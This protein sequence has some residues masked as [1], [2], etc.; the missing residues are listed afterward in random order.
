MALESSR[1]IGFGTSLIRVSNSGSHYFTLIVKP[2][3]MYHTSD[4]LRCISV[5]LDIEQL[6]TGLDTLISPLITMG[7]STEVCEKPN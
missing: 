6:S 5:V 4:I 3:C 1:R 2:D 7:V